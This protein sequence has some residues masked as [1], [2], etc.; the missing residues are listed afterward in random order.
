[1]DLNLLKK[2]KGTLITIVAL[3]LVFSLGISLVQKL[4]YGSESKVLVYQKFPGGTDIYTINRSNEYL[5]GVLASVVASDS[6]YE[7]V[8]NAGFSIDFNYF[9]KEGAGKDELKK[10]E[11]TVSA[12]PLADSGIMQ[13]D[14]YHPDRYQ[15][16]QISRAVNFV[17]MTKNQNYHGGGDSVVVKVIDKPTV[18]N[19]PVKPNILL[20]LAL[21]L[22]F[23]L[24][25]GLTYIYL[26]PEDK[27]NLSA[28]P[29]G[30]KRTAKKILIQTSNE[31]EN[32]LNHPR[33]P[34][35][36]WT[37]LANI[38][39]AKKEGQAFLGGGEKFVHRTESEVFRPAPLVDFSESENFGLESEPTSEANHQGSEPQYADFVARGDMG[40]L[41][42]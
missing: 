37:P 23:G 19:W 9:A 12:K 17:L 10:W 25:L 27:Y 13:I 32:N 22:I 21:A 8:K 14:V 4:K 26:F 30:K 3:F 16:E 41:M 18:S 11:K 39:E 15:A 34:K 24:V 20:N 40:N 5:S 28:W 6:F 33:E 36:N 7:E 2:K 1:M 31:Y 42:R 29:S 35:D 38:L